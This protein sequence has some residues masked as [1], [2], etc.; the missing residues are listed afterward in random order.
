MS[1][2]RRNLFFINIAQA[3][4]KNHV[5]A[6]PGHIN[7]ADH[8]FECRDQI[9]PFSLNDKNVISAGGKNIDQLPQ[10][11]A[12][13]RE[14]IAP[15]EVAGLINQVDKRFQV[16]EATSKFLTVSLGKAPWLCQYLRRGSSTVSLSFSSRGL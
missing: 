3:R 12:G 7:Q 11:I 4:W 14:Y 15:N 5:D 1:K 6:M 2:R 13:L 10:Q 8:A 16:P 9:L